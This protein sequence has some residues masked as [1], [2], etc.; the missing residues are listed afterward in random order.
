MNDL[1]KTKS[2][3]TVSSIFVLLLI[4]LY[5]F[6]FNSYGYVSISSAKVSFFYFLSVIYILVIIVLL[7]ECLILKIF[8]LSDVLEGLKRFKWSQRIVLLY[9]FFTAVSALLSPYRGDVWFGAGRSEGFI[10][11]FF[12]GFLYLMVSFFFKPKLWM[13][14]VFGLS[15]SVFS[16]I[17]ILQLNGYN[18]FGLY[19]DGFNYFDAYTAYSGAYL[20]TIGNVDFVSAFYCLAI[21]VIGFSVWGIKNKY[22]WLL[23]IPLVLSLYVF[24]KMRVIAGYVGI[25]I[26]II[27][28]LFVVLKIPAKS[29]KVLLILILVLLVVSLVLLYFVDL[30]VDFLHDI[31]EILHGRVEGSLGTGRIYIWTSVLSLVPDHLFFG[32]GPD[33]MALADI[34]P[35]E[36]YDENLGKTII[37]KI[38][39][40]HNEYLN[41]LYHQGLFALLCYIAFLGVL[42]F[43]WIRG[44]Q[45]NKVTTV[46]GSAALCYCVQAFFG[47]SQCM[48]AVFFW[49]ALGILEN[50]LKGGVPGNNN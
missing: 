37:G 30:N 25:L 23:L 14:S 44:A 32:T 20:G 33:T 2:F 28:S 18:P 10:T 3:E 7:M 15:V 4:T 42:C 34:K 22:R 43:R 5:L 11:I 48:S 24:I 1:K 40:A 29:R 9:L 50:S 46:F 12:Y 47:I 45:N 21:P 26:G 31:H 6:V 49:L 16:M 8:P 17:C 19:P 35:F 13:L 39:A 41:I 36:R 27:L 38:D